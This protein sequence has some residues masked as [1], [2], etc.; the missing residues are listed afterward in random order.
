VK[1][2]RPSALFSAC[3]TAG[4]SGTGAQRRRRLPK[5][6]GRTWKEESG[7]PIGMPPEGLTT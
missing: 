6:R 4:Y 3:Y 2:R 5:G 1:A 7:P